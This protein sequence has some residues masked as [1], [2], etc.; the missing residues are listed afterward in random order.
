MAD[1][2]AFVTVNNTG[3]TQ[4]TDRSVI[5]SR[6]MLG[7]N[8]QEGSRRSK[9]AARKALR[10]AA[11]SAS[12]TAERQTLNPLLTPFKPRPCET[13][14]KKQYEEDSQA[15]NKEE[16]ARNDRV[17]L[18]PPVPHPPPSDMSLI[19][20]AEEL[21]RPSQEILFRLVN[22]NA[23]K[24]TFY[25]IE[26]CVDLPRSANSEALSFSWI[27]QDK[28]FLHSALFYSSAVHE[29]V[30]RRQ[31]GKMTQFHL[32][33]TIQ[34]L[35]DALSQPDSHRNEAIFHVVL[36]L[37]L[38]AGLWGDFN[39]TAVHLSGLQQI[40]HLRG[41][42]KYLQR[43]PKLHFKLD[44]L[45]LSWALGTGGAPCFFTSP[46]GW[47]S[48]F[49]AQLTPPNYHAE[50]ILSDVVSD[51]RLAAVWQDL[52]HLVNL[53][54]Q[55]LA[56]NSLLDGSL[57]QDSLG[58][59]QTRLIRLQDQID[60]PSDE[61]L[62]LGMLA[63]LSTTLQI[64]GGKLP[65]KY[66][67]ESLKNICQPLVIQTLM[68]ERITLWLLMVGAISV[69]EADEA[70]LWPLWLN[71]GVRQLS[72]ENARSRLQSVMWIDRLQGALGQAAWAKLALINAV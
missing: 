38:M 5:R 60:T 1:N 17:A 25:P 57:F 59:I 35:N 22:I 56:C 33:R 29:H 6:C 34:L 21:G 8:R 7:R 31:P 68:N 69:L 24:G 62:R 44:R 19:R 48:C 72:W 14:K 13:H 26:H 61:C 20:F 46:V 36:T 28:I 52:R 40:V 3:R 9:Q 47:D 54:N 12:D 23:L 2:F 27:L 55:H 58:S 37:A 71:L 32:R 18:M 49:D 63:F 65:Y 4:S 64:P 53:I 16:R 51:W 10:L 15:T 67:T 70:W 43:H 41:G 11:Q 39:T 45:A 42:L 66:L 50:T 30:H